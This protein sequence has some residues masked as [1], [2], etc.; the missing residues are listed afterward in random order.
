MATPP[1]DIGESDSEHSDVGSVPSH[2]FDTYPSSYS[3]FQ[4]TTIDDK[5][6]LFNTTHENLRAVSPIHP[7]TPHPYPLADISTATTVRIPHQSYL[8]SPRPFQPFTPLTPNNSFGSY[9]VSFP[10]FNIPPGFNMFS[11]LPSTS[12]MALASTGPYFVATTTTTHTTNPV[13]TDINNMPITTIPGTSNPIIPSTS[14]PPILHSIQSVA[15]NVTTLTTQP[16]TSTAH[17]SQVNA[18]LASTYTLVPTT[19]KPATIPIKPNPYNPDVDNPINFLQTY[20]LAATANSWPIEL[21]CAYFPTFLNPKALDWYMS[22]TNIR[23]R[24]GLGQWTWEDLKKEFLKSSG[25]VQTRKSFLEYELHRRAQKTDE[26]ATTF[27]TTIDNICNHIDSTMPDEKR[28][29]FILNGLKPDIRLAIFPHSP[30]TLSE[31][32]MLLERIDEAMTLNKFDNNFRSSELVMLQAPTL[33]STPTQ[34]HQSPNPV[35]LSA[36]IDRLNKLEVSLANKRRQRDNRPIAY[37][38]GYPRNPNY[39]YTPST[40]RQWYNGSYSRPYQ[41]QPRN[42]NYAQNNYRTNTTPRQF[43]SSNQQPPRDRQ[44]QYPNSPQTP[45][46][47]RQNLPQRN[48]QA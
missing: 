26:S 3:Q 14:V 29:K 17:S 32:F 13:T 10:R 8:P 39:R 1:A 47:N 42:P 43:P 15:P 22:K 24:S 16:T 7:V 18:P 30:T 19:P 9:S 28:I 40:N 33:S 34:P 31:L 36:I 41:Q 4:S 46:P 5:Y 44:N 21:R 37:Q 23:Q 12:Q 45:P 27:A 25:S 11:N 38:P 48:N 20:E 6:D 2:E 35:D